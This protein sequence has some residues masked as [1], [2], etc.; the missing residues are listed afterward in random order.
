M[1]KQIADIRKALEVLPDTLEQ[2]I[3]IIR[4]LSCPAHGG[5]DDS[6]EARIFRYCWK[7]ALRR[8]G[9]IVPYA[10]ELLLLALSAEKPK[11]PVR[12]LWDWTQ[13]GLRCV[14]DLF[15]GGE[16]CTF[17][18]LK[19]TFERRAGSFLIYGAVSRT[20]REL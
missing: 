10:P 11:I 20:V 18:C 2:L 16:M 14:G 1:T 13:K 12:G 6:S 3:P 4:M 19:E 9:S 7:R 17:D 8:T 15:E 5:R